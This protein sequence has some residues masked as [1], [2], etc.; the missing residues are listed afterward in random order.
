MKIGLVAIF[1]EGQKT[2]I[3]YYTCNLVKEL[4][5][6][7][8]VNQYFTIQSKMMS[9][10]PTD[11]KHQ[12]IIRSPLRNLR[13]KG[14]TLFWQL[15]LSPL[16][17]RRD[18]DLS[19]VHDPWDIACFAI[20]DLHCKKVVTI[21]DIAPLTGLNTT[22]RFNVV[23]HKRL[24]PRVIKRADIIIT[25]SQF[26]KNEIVKYFGTEPDKIKVVYQGISEGFRIVPKT[27]LTPIF[28]KYKL[29]PTFILY[30]GAICKQKNIQL[31]L[32]AYSRIKKEISEKVV[33]VGPQMYGGDNNLFQLIRDLDLKE[34]VIFTGYVNDNELPL[35][36]NAASIFV[37]PSLYEG[38]GLPPLE[39][40]ACGTPVITSDRTSLPEVVGDAGL[41]VNPSDVDSMIRTIKMLLNDEDL[42]RKMIKRGLERIKMFQEQQSAQKTLEIYRELVDKGISIKT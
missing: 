30:V 31:L 41:M 25:V 38:F 10:F 14:S 17:L 28:A 42:R 29:P 35:F 23:L 32:K 16:K 4:Q 1:A 11:L 40:M 9:I 5:N 26:S 12:I 6:I 19:I 20:F 37:F 3:G 34:D 13:I 22:S 7:D 27:E 24:L 2:G 8:H 36:Y 33:I 15:F 39:S 21:H 18:I